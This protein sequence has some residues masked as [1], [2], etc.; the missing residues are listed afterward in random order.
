MES[1]MESMIEIYTDTFCTAKEECLKELERIES[2]EEFIE[3]SDYEDLR[4]SIEES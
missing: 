3:F 4:K 1:M 2:E